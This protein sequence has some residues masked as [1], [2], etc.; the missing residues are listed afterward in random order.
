MNTPPVAIT[1][2][3][4]AEP[5]TSRVNETSTGW[6][7]WRCTPHGFVDMRASRGTVNTAPFTVLVFVHAG[8]RW[9]RVFP[10]QFYTVTAATRL[11][12][13]FAAEIVRQTKEVQ[14]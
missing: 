13:K 10:H 4:K 3:T 12:T 1:K 6:T 11:A 9:E 14:P 2:D 7:A 8:R 5:F